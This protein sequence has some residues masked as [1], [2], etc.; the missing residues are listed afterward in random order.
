MQEIAQT[1]LVFHGG[2]DASKTQLAQIL[3]QAVIAIYDLD[4]GDIV[5]ILIDI[6]VDLFAVAVL[7]NDA[8]ANEAQ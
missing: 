8:Q 4:A 6:G 7:M 5:A 2:I 1:H 3:I